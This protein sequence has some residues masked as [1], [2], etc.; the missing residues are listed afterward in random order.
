MYKY[1]YPL[2]TAEEAASMIENGQTVA[3]SGFT[4]AGAAKAVPLALAKRGRELQAKGKPFQVRVLSGASTGALDENLAGSNIISWRAPYQSSRTLR[5]QINKQQVKFTDLHLSHLPQMVLFGFFG[6]IDVAV[7]E[8]VEVTS[9]GRVYL[10]TSIGA[11][12]TFLRCAEKV[13]IELNHYHS[14]RLNE[15]ADIHILPPPPNRSPIPIYTPL[16]KIGLPYMA[17]DPKK[18]VGVVEN[19]QPDGNTSLDAPT[20][21]H[22]K[23]AEQVVNFLLEELKAGRIPKDFLPLQA[24]VGNIA[25]AVMAVLGE[26]PE[27]PPFYMYTE[28]LQDS[29][30]DLMQSGK[31]L[32]VSSTSLT[33]SDEILKRVYEN[34][35]F[36]APRIVL[37]PQELSNNPGVIRRLGVISLNTALE[38]DLTGHAN[39][40]HICGKDIVNGIGGSGD[41]T[42]NAYL[43]IFMC[44]SVAKG[45]RIS[46]VVP[47]ATHGDNNEHS[48]QVLVTEQGL[49]D[50][51]GLDPM[52]RAHRIINNC[53]HP[54]YKD[55]LLRYWE[56][57]PV[58]HIRQ[59]LSKC[60]ELHRNLMEYGQMLPDLDLSQFS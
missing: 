45:G 14:V 5:S 33:I 6:K 55:Y 12:P 54:A 52:E 48:V 59:D 20:E 25:N 34:M 51:R 43:S 42:R 1:Y 13:I 27:I 44:P 15:M 24:G 40:T 17:I 35:D 31:L 46:T 29:L 53:A 30:I 56:Q 47:M 10:S 23:I 11:S 21:V 2:I 39:S 7:V 4:A 36:F 26:A 9:D 32:G 41:F 28:V 58:G 60:F 57:A 22:R 49:A 3:F 16:D 18:I 19:N 38:V 37:R 50:L 8:A